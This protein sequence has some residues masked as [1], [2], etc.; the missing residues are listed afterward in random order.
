MANEKR[1]ECPHPNCKWKNKVGSKFCEDCGKPIQ[2]DSKSNLK[3]GE[4]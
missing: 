4:G 3:G 1:V 2:E